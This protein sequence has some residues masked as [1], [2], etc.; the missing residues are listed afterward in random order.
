MGVESVDTNFKG[1]RYGHL[2]ILALAVKIAKDYD[3][4]I[5][6]EVVHGNLQATKLA[7]SSTDVKIIDT[8]SWILAKRREN[9][10]SYP[11]FG[12]L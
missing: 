9:V 8:Q 2:V 6:F 12:H 11:M 1:N 10:S 4:D 3:T 7:T 5:H